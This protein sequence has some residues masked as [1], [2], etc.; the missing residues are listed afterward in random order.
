MPRCRLPS[1]WT[2][3]HRTLA[4]F[5][6]AQLQNA[7][8]AADSISMQIVWAL[9]LSETRNL[10]RHAIF[11]DAKSPCGIFGMNDCDRHT[12]TSTF[13]GGGI[14]SKVGYP[15][16]NVFRALYSEGIAG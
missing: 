16:A 6:P 7:E 9:R 14:G 13:H 5:F 11:D 10:L 12:A 15:V 3:I 4:G 2:E 1:E 8:I